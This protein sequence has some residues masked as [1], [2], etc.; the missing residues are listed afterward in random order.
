MLQ[1]LVSSMATTC[2]QYQQQGG[3]C[4]LHRCLQRALLHAVVW[5]S[6]ASAS[7]T[8]THQVGTTSSTTTAWTTVQ[9]K[10]TSSVGGQLGGAARRSNCREGL[11]S[12]C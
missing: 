3:R 11:L 7:T 5:L 9:G 2:V 4:V 1:L 6:R 10:D 12:P 8:T